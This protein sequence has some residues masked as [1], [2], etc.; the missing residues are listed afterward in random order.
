ML[1]AGPA[2]MALADPAPGLPSTNPSDGGGINGRP[3]LPNGAPAPVVQAIQ[4][5]GDPVF[6]NN[7][8]LNGTSL[9]KAYHGLYGTSEAA[10]QAQDPTL[11]GSQGLSVGVLNQVPRIAGCNI[12]ITAGCVSSG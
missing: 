11:H 3:S 6:D 1:L 4:K 9:G 10:A 2:A 5:A 8:F 12:V 7:S